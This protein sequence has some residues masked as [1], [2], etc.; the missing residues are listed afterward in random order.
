MVT[1]PTLALKLFKRTIKAATNNYSDNDEKVRGKTCK[2]IVRNNQHLLGPFKHNFHY[3]YYFRSKAYVL[4][5][6]PNSKSK[7]VQN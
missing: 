3:Y 4:K 5:I 2:L 6:D 7:K 1:E